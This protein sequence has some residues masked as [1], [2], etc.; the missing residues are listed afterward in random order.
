MKH[1][2]RT[3]ALAVFL[4]LAAMTRASAQDVGAQW[5]DR[6]TRELQA[7]RLPVTQP[8]QFTYGADAG[9][10]YAYDS[11][12]FLTQND[13]TSDEIWIPFVQANAAYAEPQWEVSGD[14]MVD[15][16]YYVHTHNARDTEERV[17]LKGGYAGPVVGGSLVQL[18]RNESDPLDAT[19]ANRDQRLVSDTLPRA[20]VELTPIFAVEADGLVEIVRFKDQTLA[21]GRD[22]TNYNGA[23]SLVYKTQVSIDFIVKGGLRYIHYTGGKDPQ[24]NPLAPPN[25][26]AEYFMSGVRGELRPDLTV[27]AL[28]GGE[29]ISTGAFDFV[30]MPGHDSI[31]HNTMNAAVWLRYKAVE[32]L[33][34]SVGYTRDVGFLGGEDPYQLVDSIVL[35]ADYHA[36]E[37]VLL[38]ANVQ[39][40]RANS[41]LAVHRTYSSAGLIAT[42]RP[43]EHVVID[44]GVTGRFG[45]V[46]G[47][48]ATDVR[49][50]DLILQLGVAL[51]W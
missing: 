24:G 28:V 10:Q 40:S 6:I 14:L 43:L 39:Y 7:D 36:M 30:T 42:W 51:A 11:N 13:R 26:T 34:A 41:A 31:H 4:A 16:K 3:S 9:L 1:S 18:I 25:V 23:L 22:N 29:H 48:V 12:I 5:V 46:T 44:G 47:T 27:D 45:D 49:Y 38:Q 17:M 33:T 8:S 21:D 2:G 20:Y 19:F 50:T 32:R 37:Q 35:L 15:Y